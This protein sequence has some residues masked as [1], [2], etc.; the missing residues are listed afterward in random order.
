M[1]SLLSC[2][3][4]LSANVNR[5]LYV[6][7]SF[8]LSCISCWLIDVD[9]NFV[10]LLFFYVAVQQ[11]SCVVFVIVS[12]WAELSLLFFWCLSKLF[13]ISNE[14]FKLWNLNEFLNDVAG[15]KM[16][17]CFNILL[18]RFIILFHFMKLIG[19]ILWN[20]CNYIRREFRFNSYVLRVNKKPLFK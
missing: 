19:V 11:Q 13:K 12:Y 9:L 14:I 2:G 10:K 16:T 15:I 1:N 18:N 3:L 7:N 20:F 17:D 6:E 4:V 8:V 5:S